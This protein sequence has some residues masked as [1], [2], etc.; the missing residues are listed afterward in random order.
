MYIH[1]NPQLP[2]LF[3]LSLLILLLSLIHTVVHASYNAPATNAHGTVR[4][5]DRSAGHE[6][7]AP[8]Y[9]CVTKDGV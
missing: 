4:G 6:V 8:V 2:S 1:Y 3:S 5:C 9:L 7:G